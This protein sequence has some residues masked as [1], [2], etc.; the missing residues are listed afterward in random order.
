[1]TSGGK[2]EFGKRVTVDLGFCEI[3]TGSE[4]YI[5]TFGDVSSTISYH[6]PK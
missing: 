2:K 1:M 4:L 6:L 5:D 3:N